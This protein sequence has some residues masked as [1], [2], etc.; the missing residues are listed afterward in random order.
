MIGV[1]LAGAAAALLAL[2]VRPLK[3]EYS[4]FLSLAAIILLLGAAVS[5]LGTILELIQT[6]VND[7]GLDLVYYKILLKIMG[8][9][10]ISQL[11]SDICKEAGCS[12]ISHQI[13]IY[14]KLLILSVSLPVVN[15]LIDTIKTLFHV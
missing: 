6:L 14:G 1:I 7:T 12:A 2:W 5:Q 3:S 8:L 13:D 11:A 4:L 9:A 15:A 10:W